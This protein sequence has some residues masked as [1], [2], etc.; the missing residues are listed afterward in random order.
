[1]VCPATSPNAKI[2]Y[3]DAQHC[4]CSE[5]QPTEKNPD[6]TAAASWMP[7]ISK[8][9]RPLQVDALALY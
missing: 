4:L 8:T 1:M 9:N 6:G 5:N 2:N 3:H 7:G